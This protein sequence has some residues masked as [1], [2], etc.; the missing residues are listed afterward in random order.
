MRERPAGGIAFRQSWRDIVFLHYPVREDELRKFVPDS[1]D[2]DLWPTN[3]GDESA[4]IG[5]VA[6]RILNARPRG[7][8][9]FAPLSNFVEI[10]VRTYVHR[11]GAEPGIFFFSLD[12][13]QPLAVK[14]ARMMY[15]LPYWLARMSFERTAENCE[16]HCDRVGG[17]TT[18]VAAADLRVT[19]GPA[20]GDS[21][22]GSTEFFFAERYLAYSLI[23]NQ[24]H[25][26]RVFHRPYPLRGAILNELHESLSASCQLPHYAIQHTMVSDGVD[27]E[28]YHAYR[29]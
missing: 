19:Y 14:I 4:W 24:L 11:Q 28:L 17:D 1:L 16:Y 13:S 12:A 5:I 7:L 6:F 2:L 18:G 22:P 15:G 21:T 20:T 26:F 8:P 3:S 23:E 27:V 10:N 29:I 25:G 9:A